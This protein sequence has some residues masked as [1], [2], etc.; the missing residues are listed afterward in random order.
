[1]PEKPLYQDDRIKVDY[2]PN[3]PEDHVIFIKEKEGEWLQ[4]MLQRSLLRETAQ[5]PRGNLERKVSN[6]NPELVDRIKTEGIGIDWLHVALC[7]AYIEEEKRIQN[8]SD[9]DDLDGI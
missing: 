5:T 3:S 6:F 2:L 4:Y 9:L 8:F 1:M 7:Q